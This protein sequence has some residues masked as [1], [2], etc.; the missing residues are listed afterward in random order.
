M[1]RTSLQSTERKRKRKDGG[2]SLAERLKYW[3]DVQAHMDSTKDIDKK[4]R[5]PPAKGSKKGCMKGKGGPENSGCKYRGV[6]QRTWGKWVAEIREPNR[7]PRLWLGTFPDAIDAALAYDEAARAMYG[8]MA[9]LNFSNYSYICEE[10]DSHSEVCHVAEDSGSS[11]LRQGESKYKSD[12]ISDQ[13][14]MK[15]AVKNDPDIVELQTKQEPLDVFDHS[16]KLQTY[17]REELFDVEEL[18]GLLSNPDCEPGLDQTLD[19]API[20]ASDLSYQLQNPDAKLLG[21]LPEAQPSGVDYWG[22]DEQDFFAGLSDNWG[23]ENQLEETR[24]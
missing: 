13:H 14:E 10:S 3:K 16:K 19:F 8:P 11:E 1:V 12:D 7:G 15:P 23:F 20:H 17:S 18:L 5:R 9:R 21:S 22:F 24:F 2:V 6:R 4:L